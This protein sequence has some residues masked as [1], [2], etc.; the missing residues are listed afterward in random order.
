MSDATASHHIAAALERL[1]P[2]LWESCFTPLPPGQ[3]AELPVGQART[4]AHLAVT[5]RRR[6][7]ELA[8][9]LGVRVPTATRIVDRLEERHLA[10]RHPDERDRRVVWVE[11]TSRGVT[12]A[13]E[14]RRFRREVIL[15][16]LEHLDGEQLSALGHALDLLEDAVPETVVGT[17]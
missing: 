7:G 10:A 3:F 8:D 2:R 12:L 1:L 9:D 6:M 17:R 16:R 4:L 11:A 14:A 15:R 5:G 13:D